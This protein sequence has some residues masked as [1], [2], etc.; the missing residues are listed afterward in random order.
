MD[1]GMRDKG[2]FGSVYLVGTLDILPYL[3]LHSDTLPCYCEFVTLT[4][5][6]MVRPRIGPFLVKWIILPRI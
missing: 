5:T 4:V 2:T 6:G 1:G 3:R